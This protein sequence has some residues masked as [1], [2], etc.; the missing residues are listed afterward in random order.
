MLTVNRHD[1]DG[2]WWE[3]YKLEESRRTVYKR[4]QCGSGP[5]EGTKG[6]FII[7]T[8]APPSEEITFKSIG[9]VQGIGE[10]IEVLR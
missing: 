3:M 4:Q 10:V 9:A 1:R 7:L 8:R 2:A 5:F 6:G